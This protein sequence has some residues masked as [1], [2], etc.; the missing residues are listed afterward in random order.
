MEWQYLVVLIITVPIIVLPAALVWYINA[1]GLYHAIRRAR[2]HARRSAPASQGESHREDNLAPSYYLAGS[3]PWM[4]ATMGR[5]RRQG[6][7]QPYHRANK[8]SEG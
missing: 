7:Y 2:A 8:T 5:T 4:S 6:P 3:S 1:G